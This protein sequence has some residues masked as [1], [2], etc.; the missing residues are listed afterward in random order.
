MINGIYCTRIGM[1][2]LI[3]VNVRNIRIIMY[4]KSEDSERHGNE[5]IS[6]DK[7]AKP[8]TRE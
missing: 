3:V 7:T 1:A 2:S 6:I 5:L 4:V 8:Q